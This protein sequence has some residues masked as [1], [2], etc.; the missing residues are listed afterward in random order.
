MKTGSRCLLKS[1]ISIV[2]SRKLA[3][4]CGQKQCRYWAQARST[5]YNSSIMAKT[6]GRGRKNAADKKATPDEK[7]SEAIEQVL[8]DSWRS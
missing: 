2:V 8:S 1:S 5:P 4:G 6:M 3:S 7:L